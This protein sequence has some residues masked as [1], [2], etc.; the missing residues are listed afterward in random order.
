MLCCYE[1]YTWLSRDRIKKLAGDKKKQTKFASIKNAI[2][3]KY[4]LETNPSVYPH[5]MIHRILAP[6]GPLRPP[7]VP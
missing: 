5:Y 7:T 4:D 2:D 6:Y 1:V 3:L